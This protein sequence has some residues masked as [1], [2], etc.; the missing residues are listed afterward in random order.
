MEAWWKVQSGQFGVYV[1]CASLGPQSH[2]KR[3]ARLRVWVRHL[4]I[5]SVNTKQATKRSNM[6]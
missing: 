1:V 3:E 5:V 2:E 6:G 4:G